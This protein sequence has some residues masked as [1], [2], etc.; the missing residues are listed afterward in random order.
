MLCTFLL[1][2]SV[3]C[4]SN[5]DLVIGVVECDSGTAALLA[6]WQ[7]H[8][9]SLNICCQCSNIPGQSSKCH[10]TNLPEHFKASQRQRWDQAFSPS[11]QSFTHAVSFAQFSA[12]LRSS[13]S[14]TSYVCRDHVDTQLYSI[15]KS[16]LF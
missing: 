11:H 15:Q 6:S 9:L 2:W 4:S 7:G 3:S 8:L 1:C 10:V 12:N 16:M 5:F 14:Y 13:K